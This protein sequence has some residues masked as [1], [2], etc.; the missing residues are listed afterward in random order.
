MVNNARILHLEDDKDDADLYQLLLN[1]IADQYGGP[2]F[3]FTWAP[4]LEEAMRHVEAESYDAVL[5]DYQVGNETGI[6][7]LT[8]F[9]S[10]HTHL[11]FIFLTGHGDE[12]VAREAFMSGA[13]DYFVKDTGL[14]GPERLYN[15]LMHHMRHHEN[16][17]RKKLFQDTLD[18][19]RTQSVSLLES[20]NDA[21]LVIDVGT[22]EVLY[23]NEA[24]SSNF[25]SGIVGARCHEALHGVPAPCDG[26]R[27]EQVRSRI[28]VMHYER[29]NELH[30]RHYRVI[31]KKVTWIDGSEAIFKLCTDI[32][33]ETRNKEKIRRLERLDGA[34][35]AV[36]RMFAREGAGMPKERVL[37][38]LGRALGAQRVTLF[39]LEGHTLRA[40]HEW[41][42]EGTRAVKDERGQIPL[43]RLEATISCLE[44]GI[45]VL[46]N[47]RSEA[48]SDVAAEQARIPGRDTGSI[49]MIPLLDASMTLLGAICLEGDE[50]TF[51]EDE[52]SLL[53][54]IADLLTVSYKNSDELNDLRTYRTFIE[55]TGTAIVVLDEDMTVL[56]AN[57]EFERLSGR[58]KDALV[59]QARFS[60]F[61][62]PSDTWRIERYHLSRRR[63]GTAPHAYQFTFV[64]ANGTERRVLA[65][66]GLIPHTP[67]SIVSLIDVSMQDKLLSAVDR[68]ENE[69][70]RILDALSEHIIYY[71]P[72]HRIRWAN[73]AA[74]EDLG[75]PMEELR[76]NRCHAIRF[77]SEEPCPG[78]PVRRC[79]ETG[80]HQEEETAPRNGRIYHVRADPIYHE[81]VFLGVVEIAQDVTE[82]RQLQHDLERSEDWLRTTLRSIGDAVIVTD[83][84]ARIVFMNPV[85]ASLTRWTAN[86]ALG[87][88][89]EE[90]FDIA[91]EVTGRRPENPAMRALRHG[92]VV[93]L[94]NHTILIARDGTRLPIEDSASPICDADGTVHGVVLVFRD[95]TEKREAFQRLERQREELSAFAHTVA[96]EM[97]SHITVIDGYA[98]ILRED[99]VASPYLDSIKSRVGMMRSYI[100]TQLQLADAGLIVGDPVDVDLDMVVSS[101][102]SQYDMTVEHAGLPTIK[103][104]RQKI[105]QLFNILLDNAR[106]H[107]GARTVTITARDEGDRCTITI[108]D[109]GRGI[110]EG[111][112]DRVFD[113]GFSTGSTGFG[114][115]IAKKIVDAHNGSI[116]VSSAPG[117]GAT[118]ELTL[119]YDR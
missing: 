60:E 1:R 75:V 36:V 20:M 7:F 107:G 52:L 78:C 100:S 64:D 86:D 93:G 53:T 73:R 58:S 14:M 110:P 80:V 98:D 40:R 116:D 115:A 5:C 16:G 88:P 89:L 103:G 72:E 85:A 118:F 25:G 12:M 10:R 18:H 6:D 4:S 96:H 24:A 27:M 11:P 102:S 63:G 65:T 69:K 90:V 67:R 71:S 74:R 106:R 114:L 84:D 17:R 59:G 50:T 70:R 47:A 111:H 44:G 76:G 117:R 32:T 22:Y 49:A 105:R 13:T 41:C 61:I 108:T 87:R 43:E 35:S 3:S 113:L 29:H 68:S 101:L 92:T 19:L 104:E 28:D 31:D 81:G 15:A 9:R 77:G 112:L 62:S 83:T 38:L 109:D 51:E 55:N 46:L 54:S 8:W 82:K 94:A 30:D 34:L 56:L 119:P 23:A 21:V 42:G 57:R 66:V 33:E 2:R 79:I 26:C 97:K 37:P 95:A 45:P 39:Y 48:L 99:S 91:S